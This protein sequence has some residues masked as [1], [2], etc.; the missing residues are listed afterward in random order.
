MDLINLIKNNDETLVKV[1]LSNNRLVEIEEYGDNEK[2]RLMKICKRLSEALGSNNVIREIDLSNNK[3]TDGMVIILCEGICNCKSLE[4]VDLKKN[5]FSTKAAFVLFRKLGMKRLSIIKQDLTTFDKIV[6]QAVIRLEFVKGIPKEESFELLRQF[7]YLNGLK[8]ITEEYARNEHLFKQPFFSKHEEHLSRIVRK[9]EILKYINENRELVESIKIKPLGITGL[10][11]TGTTKLF[12]LLSTD[13][14]ARSPKIWEIWDA[15]PP[16]KE[17]TYKTDKRIQEG[18]KKVNSIYASGYAIKKMHEI[19]AEW[20]EECLFVL[21][22]N[23]IYQEYHLNNTYPEYLDYYHSLDWDE[24]YRECK[25]FYQLLSVNYLN[26]SQHWVLK[27][28]YHLLRLKEL[29]RVYDFDCNV[30]FC[31]RDPVKSIPSTISL[32]ATIG[33]S[34]WKN[35]DVE[36]IALHILNLLADAWDKAI[37]YLDELTNQG[38]GSK[39]YHVYFSDLMNDPVDTCNK[40]HQ[41]FNYPDIEPSRITGWLEDNPRNKHGNHNYSLKGYGLSKELVHEKFH[42]YYERFYPDLLTSSSGSCSIN[43]NNN[44][45]VCKL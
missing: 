41:Y 19:N 20:P 31:H 23:F 13:V 16:P 25:L 26:D 8:L 32:F 37:D 15:V 12:N 44:E 40:I 42:K 24:V 10:F 2:K 29:F 11:R 35:L 14:N 5:R 34:E 45:N 33:Q 22:E 9:V 18:I 6:E 3:L 39:I 21:R 36:A 43:N 30:V 28:P 4:L 1:D 17:E 27:A 38:H 7:K